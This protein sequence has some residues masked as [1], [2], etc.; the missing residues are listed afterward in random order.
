[1]GRKP[2]RKK[3]G[4]IAKAVGIAVLLAMLFICVADFTFFICLARVV[5]TLEDAAIMIVLLMIMVLAFSVLM[6]VLSFFLKNYYK[7]EEDKKNE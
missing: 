4:R 3:K 7:K 5:R 1:M 2:R 6:I